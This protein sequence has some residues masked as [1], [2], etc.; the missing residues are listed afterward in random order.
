M[1][2]YYARPEIFVDR[3]IPDTNISSTLCKCYIIQSEAT[4]NGAGTSQTS[5]INNDQ[6]QVINTCSGDGGG[7]DAKLDEYC[8]DYY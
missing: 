8:R 3:I 5:Y 6:T 4:L 2:R 1:K 7:W